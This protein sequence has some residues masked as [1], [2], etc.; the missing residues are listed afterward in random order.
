MKNGHGTGTGVI[1]YIILMVAVVVVV[2]MLFFKH[3]FWKRLVAN[4]II[5]LAF[6]A[7]YFVFLKHK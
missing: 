2:D 1:L 7:F 6:A 3:R 4:I 5:A